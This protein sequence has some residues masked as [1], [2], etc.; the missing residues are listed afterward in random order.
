MDK[1]SSLT[2]HQREYQECSMMLFAETWLMELTPDSTVTL[3]G[4]Q[5]IRA[6]RTQ[7]RGKR[8]GGGIAVLVNDI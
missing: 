2:R 8:K 1:L 5:L 3:D 7:E 6:V 4:F